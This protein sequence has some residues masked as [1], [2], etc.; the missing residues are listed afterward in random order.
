MSKPMVKFYDVITKE[1]IIREMNDEEFAQYEIDKA[2]WEAKALEEPT[3][4]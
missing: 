1:E 2:A 4:D 3:N